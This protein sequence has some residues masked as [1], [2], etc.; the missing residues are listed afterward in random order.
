LNAKIP[1]KSDFPQ[2]GLDYF[3]AGKGLRI[4]H[5]SPGTNHDLYFEYAQY[6]Q[7]IQ[8]VR[9]IRLSVKNGGNAVANDVKLV[10]K[11]PENPNGL[12]VYHAD[13]LPDKPAPDTFT[14]SLYRTH[15]IGQKDIT[16][17]TSSQ[18]IVVTCRLGKIQAMDSAQSSDLLCVGS[19]SSTAVTCAVE[20]FSDDLDAPIIEQLDLSVTVNEKVYCVEEFTKIE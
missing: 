18:G 17:K 13:N 3:P 16:V 1:D 4:A 9:A 19:Y 5:M 20:I 8:R 6:F 15:N 14:K 11:F 7:K 10:L 2:Y 12:I